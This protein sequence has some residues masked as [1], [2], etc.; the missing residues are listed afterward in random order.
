[1]SKELHVGDKAPAFS[2]PDQAGKI[3]SLADYKGKWLLL[4]FYPKD[5]TDGCTREA[6]KIR[7]AWSLFE[8]INM[9][10]LGVS[11]DSV[12]SHKEFAGEYKLPFPIL[13][14]EDKKIIGLYGAWGE[15]SMYGHKYMGILRMSYIISP[16]G[17]IAKIYPKVQSAKHAAEVLKDMKSLQI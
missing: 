6:C 14:D 16:D 8:G 10:V 9:K 11:A 1:M 5:M 12:D 3:H 4:Y 17:K 15:K 2:A 7:D 13:A